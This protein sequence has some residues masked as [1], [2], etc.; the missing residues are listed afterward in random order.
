MKFIKTLPY[1]LKRTLPILGIAGAS[2][3]AGC[4]KD[5]EPTPPGLHDTVY[6]WKGED[7]RNILPP[8]DVCMSADSANVRYVILQNINSN[9]GLGD[10]GWFREL[11]EERVLS[12]VTLQNQYKVRARGELKRYI[13]DD[14]SA[15]TL[16]K[17]REDSIWLTN[18]GLKLSEPVSLKHFLE[19]FKVR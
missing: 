18:F 13:V 12:E 4:N 9:A 15:E 6:T 11:L 7:T 2:L 10:L 3:L 1:K 16:Q 19:S 8:V 17:H 5:D 14:T